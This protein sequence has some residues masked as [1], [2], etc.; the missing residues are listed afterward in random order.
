MKIFGLFISF[1]IV[2]SLILFCDQKKSTGPDDTPVKK[3]STKLFLRTD[4]EDKTTPEDSPHTV[5][6]YFY[7]YSIKEWKAVLNKGI[8][9][10]FYRFSLWLRTDALQGQFHISLL[11][12]HTGIMNELAATDIL[13]PKHDNFK[14]YTSE[15]NGK[16]GGLAGDMLKLRISYSEVSGGGRGELKY[17]HYVF[18][19]DSHIVLPDDI[20]ISKL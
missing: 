6:S 1:C 2:L 19:Y 5:E 3:D 13:V 18:D 10:N 12:S 4:S 7:D 14:N 11:V 8:E 20:T 17:G 16:S 15:V 9:S